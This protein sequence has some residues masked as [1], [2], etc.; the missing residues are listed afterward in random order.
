MPNGK[1]L[2]IDA[3]WYDNSYE[4]HPTAK[5]QEAYSP[6]YITYNKAFFEHGY[7]GTINMHGGLSDASG[8]ISN[9]N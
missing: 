6:Y 2:Y 3:T 7:G 9:T 8:V 5:N 4:N 1:I